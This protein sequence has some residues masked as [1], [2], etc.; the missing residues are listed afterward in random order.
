MALPSTEIGS[1]LTDEKVVTSGLFEDEAVC[2]G[3]PGSM[4]D[5]LIRGGWT[6]QPDIGPDG[7]VEK[8]GLLRDD[9]DLGSEIMAGCLAKVDSTDPDG[10]LLWIIEPKEQAGQGGFS[11]AAG[12]DEC[13]EA[14]RAGS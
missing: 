5:L 4:L 14:D 10:A 6:S 3:G 1:A 7:I 2:L 13:H 9:R 12:P 8:D 11:R